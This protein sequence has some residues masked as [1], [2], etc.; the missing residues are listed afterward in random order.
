MKNLMIVPSTLGYGEATIAIKF[1]QALEKHHEVTFLV[2]I[3]LAPLFKQLP[4]ATYWLMPNNHQINKILIDDIVESVRPNCIV[5]V[6]YLAYQ[7]S[8][9][10]FGLDEEILLS[11]GVPIVSFDLY[12]WT[13]TNFTLDTFHRQRK[14]PRSLIDK[15]DVLLRPCPLNFPKAA[16][17]G[18]VIKY[19][20]LFPK[21]VQS[22]RKQ[23]RHLRDAIGCNRDAKIVFITTALWQ[24]R[25][26]NYRW[27]NGVIT[28]LANLLAALEDKVHIVHVGPEK[29]EA[30]SEKN[31]NYTWYP[32]CSPQRFDNLVSIT[33]LHISLNII[34]TTLAKM[35]ASLIPSLLLQ[36][37]YQLPN[38]EVESVN[39]GTVANLLTTR[40]DNYLPI[41]P[42]KV[43]PLGWY[44]F[45][46]P[47]LN[48]NPFMQ[49]FV[50]AEILETS[51]SIDAIESLLFDHSAIANQREQQNQYQE[52]MAELTTASLVMDELAEL[53]CSS[54]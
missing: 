20:S 11:F 5:L 42:Y 54:A 10:D 2:S 39:N 41:H 47:V 21:P 14:V 45:L 44:D 53:F 22:T 34:A 29:L 26:L 9:D 30:I 4:F 24:H 48:S 16:N 1:A 27:T 52:K 15:S 17:N 50:T 49:T 23:K 43:W 51:H 31:A 33:D 7:Y 8:N 6:D 19:Y 46:Q 12:E 18:S 40:T 32:V 35:V 36:N 37:S 13:E 25:L 28:E 38:A 3:T